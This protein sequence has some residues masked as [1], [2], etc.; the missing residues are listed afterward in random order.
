[1]PLG[2]EIY[3]IKKNKELTENRI[4]TG[5]ELKIK[6]ADLD[7]EGQNLNLAKGGKGGQGNFKAKTMNIVQ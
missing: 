6:I 1:M 2:T 7:E 3:E 4:D 5:E